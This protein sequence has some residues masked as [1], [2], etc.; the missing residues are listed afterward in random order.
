MSDEELIAIENGKIPFFLSAKSTTT[1]RDIIIEAKA[2][3]HKGK[4]LSNGF[5]E[6]KW[7]KK[8]AGIVVLGVISSLLAWAI[9]SFFRLV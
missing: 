4:L 8:P 2:I 9:L 6:K 5:K 3:L 7:H 1:A